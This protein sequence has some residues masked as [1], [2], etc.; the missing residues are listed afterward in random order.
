[1]VRGTFSPARA[2]RPAAGAR[3]ARTLGVMN[4]PSASI[5][6][7]AALIPPS[8]GQESGKVFYSGRAAFAKPADLYILG[9]N[10][11]GDPVNY[12]I[13][14]VGHH[15]RQVLE[16]LPE[17]WSAYRDEIWE[18]APPGTWGMAPRVLHLFRQLGVQPDLVPASNL[19]F[20]RSRREEH[21]K[22][23]QVMLAEMCWPFHARV[24]EVLRPKV[25]L[26]L[27]N[28]AGKYVCRRL[29]A[30][31]LIDE[32]IEQND[33]HW[34]NQTFASSSGAHVVVA[35]HPSVA[36]WSAS[37]TDPSALVRRALA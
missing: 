31:K 23:R 8:L 21:I 2:W 1:V 33:R 28:T 17:N 20:V 3:L 11:G 10:P 15:T 27:G 4:T 30:K 36:D 7:F 35:T 37:A 26:C 6:Q 18:G 25:V 32:F 9:A 29:G 14:T 16:E 24:I 12:P 13:E 34:K 19:I 5:E 22:Q